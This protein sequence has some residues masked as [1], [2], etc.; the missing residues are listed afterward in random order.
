MKK[1]KLFFTCFLLLGFL[2]IF[3]EVIGYGDEIE[4]F[5]IH[6]I[7]YKLA[8]QDL[9][10]Q[11]LPTDGTKAEKVT[12]EQGND[13]QPLSNIGYEITKVVLK[14]ATGD[15]N[16][17]D[18]YEPIQGAEAFQMKIITN[19]VGLAEVNG[20]PRSTYL[21]TEL[22][23]NLLK[24]VMEPVIIQLPMKTQS[25]IVNDVYLYPKSTIYTQDTIETDRKKLPQTN[26]TIG[27]INQMIFMIVLVLVMGITGLFLSK[28]KTN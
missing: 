28:R 26:G 18:L 1:I 7:K 13:L 27:T 2:L 19:E 11:Q 15:S 3:S 20:L 12:D 4:S 14:E 25:G 24:E 5:G 21:V 22:P 9:T 6:I 8:E 16:N 23:N 10:K 17:L